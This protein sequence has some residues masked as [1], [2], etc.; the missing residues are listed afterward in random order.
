MEEGQIK[1]SDHVK[2]FEEVDEI[3]ARTFVSRQ[4]HM[5]KSSE[6]ATKTL[7]IDRKRIVKQLSKIE[8][9]LEDL[10]D[11]KNEWWIDIL[12]IE[13][14]KGNDVLRLPTSPTPTSPGPAAA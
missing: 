14:I 9:H 5:D 6:L 10:K 8:E 12:T 11:G 7:P 4:A 1:R 3:N 13:K 2:A